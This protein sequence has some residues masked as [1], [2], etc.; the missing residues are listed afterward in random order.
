MV[1]LLDKRLLINSG[2]GGVGKSTLSSALA[3]L[4]AK[5]GK[6][7]LLAE[8]DTKTDTFGRLHEVFQVPELEYREREIYPNLF[9]CA[10]D[11]DHA[12]EE[13][14]VSVIK[15]RSLFKA[16]FDLEVV[17]NAYVAAPGI[18][19]L[20]IVLKLWMLATGDGGKRRPYDLVVYDAPATGHGLFFLK[21]PQV[22]IDILGAGPLP[23]KAKEVLTL[24]HDPAK[25]RLNL[26]T[27]PFEMPVVETI[28]YLEQIR[29][30]MDVQL[31][32]VFLNALHPDPV[33]KGLETSFEQ[34]SASV[35][36]QKKLGAAL[37]EEAL[38]P[39]LV[40]CVSETR[41]RHAREEEQ[42]ARLRRPDVP[43]I[44]VPFIH[45]ERFDKTTILGIARHLEGLVT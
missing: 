10:L 5:K 15:V 34:L 39:A 25:T 14:V 8:S 4:A 13:Y 27:L 40:R 20:A 24:L 21:M 28:E 12:L 17:R 44:E 45:A 6:R 38:G 37:G 22:L 23:N 43:L 18:K 19:E 32:T 42:A 3:V 1:P 9:A 31:G 26:V 2:K 16:V 30:G 11:A 35:A 7:V 29:K 33:P 41:I 36:A